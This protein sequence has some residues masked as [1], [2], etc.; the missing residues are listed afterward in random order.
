MLTLVNNYNCCLLNN[1]NKAC[2]IFILCFYF[3]SLLS[4][5]DK[6][7]LKTFVLFDSLPGFSVN[8]HLVF[9]LKF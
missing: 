5:L 3:F 4:Y 7:L 6:Y 1:L 8:T 2:L 9:C